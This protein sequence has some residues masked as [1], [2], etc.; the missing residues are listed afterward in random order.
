MEMCPRSLDEGKDGERIGIEGFDMD[1]STQSWKS[2]R[3]FL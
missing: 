2:S 1:S 3:S